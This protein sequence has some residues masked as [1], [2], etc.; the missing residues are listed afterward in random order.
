MAAAPPF[1][2]GEEGVDNALTCYKRLVDHKPLGGG[3]GLTDGPELTKGQLLFVSDFVLYCDNVV[4]KLVFPV[5]R[6]KHDLSRKTGSEHDFV[7]DCGGFGAGGVYLTFLQEVA[8]LNGYR[9]VPFLFGVKGG[10]VASLYKGTEL[11]LDFGKRTFDTVE[12]IFKNSGAEHKGKGTSR[13][14]NRLAGFQSHG[15]LIYLNGGGVVLNADDLSD[16]PFISHID[17]FLHG[18]SLRSP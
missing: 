6:G 5:R 13:S 1:A 12:Y 15:H 7:H 18:K 10:G 9:H 8:D 11:F 17:H 3:S 14:H 16:Q 2:M 4:V